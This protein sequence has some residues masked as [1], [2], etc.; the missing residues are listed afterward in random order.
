MDCSTC[1]NRCESMLSRQDLERS[2]VDQAN[3]RKMRLAKHMTRPAMPFDAEVLLDCED[4]D[5]RPGHAFIIDIGGALRFAFAAL[6]PGGG[7]NLHAAYDPA[8]SEA[9]E[10]SAAGKAQVIGRVFR[11]DWLTG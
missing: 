9:V 6:L 1:T 5:L 8:H 3:I 4:Q 11:V 2:G 10:A 7:M